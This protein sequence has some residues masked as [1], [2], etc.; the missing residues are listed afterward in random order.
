MN[1]LTLIRLQVVLAML[2]EDAELARLVK[3]LLKFY[4]PSGDGG[5]NG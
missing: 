4:F 5:E 2:Q 3:A 1:D